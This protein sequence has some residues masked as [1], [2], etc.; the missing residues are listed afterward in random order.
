MSVTIGLWNSNGLQATFSSSRI[1]GEN[2]SFT[3]ITQLFHSYSASQILE[4][5]CLVGLLKL[6][7]YTFDAKYRPGKTNPADSWSRLL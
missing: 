7:E 1:W 2:S 4:A 5:K 6:L 3:P